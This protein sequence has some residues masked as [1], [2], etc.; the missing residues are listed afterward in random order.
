MHDCTH[1]LARSLA[2]LEMLDGTKVEVFEHGMSLSIVALRGTM[3]QQWILDFR[4]ALGECPHPPQFLQ[5]SY[6]PSVLHSAA[7]YR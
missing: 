1:I 3:P 7:A 4:S 6:L 5:G 2:Q